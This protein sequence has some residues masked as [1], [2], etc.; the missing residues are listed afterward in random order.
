MTSFKKILVPTDFSAH[1]ESALSTALDL[2]KQFD[3]SVTLVHVF[4][5]IAL[6]FPDPSAV[7]NSALAADAM[8]ETAKTLNR[9]RDEASAKASTAVEAVLRTGSPTHEIVDFARSNGFDLIVMGTHGR[10]GLAHMLIGSVAERVVRTA[11]CGVLIV[12]PSE[13]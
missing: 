3:A 9:M 10:T 1:A 6:A 2:A 5:P 12:R 13:T 4:K 8:N 7:Y 11:P